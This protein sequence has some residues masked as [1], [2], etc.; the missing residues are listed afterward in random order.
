M[1]PRPVPVTEAISVHLTPGWVQAGV[2]L[3]IGAVTVGAFIGRMMFAPAVPTARSLD[4]LNFKMT[5]MQD[6]MRDTKVDVKEIKNILTN[7]EA[8]PPQIQA[9]RTRRYP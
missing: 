9:H 2:G 1:A 4:A 5:T 8:K 3:I 6:D 7:R